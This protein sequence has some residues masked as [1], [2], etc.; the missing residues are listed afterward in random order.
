MTDLAKRARVPILSLEESL[1]AAE[2]A[3]VPAEL[4]D[5]N[6]FR[7]LL[8]CPGLAKGINDVLYSLLF[9]ASLSDRHRELVIMRIG[10]AT[11]SDYEWTQ[12]WHVAQNAFGCDPEDLLAVRN[13]RR[14]T[15][16]DAADRAVLAA[17]DE[18]LETGRVGADT[19]AE[20]EH[21]LGSSEACIELVAAIA[22]WRL[23]SEITRSLDIPLESG[24]SSWPPDGTPP[25]TARPEP[26]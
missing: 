20:C 22:A 10:W 14:S 16:L 13:W 3:G 7:A 17:T 4:A 23:I 2:A 26:S 25:D 21:R 11:G 24:T 5:R 12:H 1:E 19:W 18:T 6:L 8:S 9:G 15:R